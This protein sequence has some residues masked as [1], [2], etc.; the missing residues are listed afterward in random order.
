MSSSPQKNVDML[1]A[2]PTFCVL[3]DYGIPRPWYFPLQESYWFG[4]GFPKAKK[5]AAA[6]GELFENS[7]IWK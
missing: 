1:Y 6:D 2:L 5:T 4:S 3:G 7:G